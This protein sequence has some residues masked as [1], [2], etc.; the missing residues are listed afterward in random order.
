MQLP[1]TAIVAGAVG[2]VFASGKSPAFS[3]VILILDIASGAAPVLV[4]VIGCAAVESPTFS[5]LKLR[6]VGAKTIAGVAGTSVPESETVTVCVE[7]FAVSVT[8]R[9]SCADKK[10][11]PAA[12]FGSFGAN[13]TAIVHVA[14]GL[15]ADAVEAQVLEV[16]NSK[17][18]G[19]VP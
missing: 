6:E 10:S 7:L 13:C 18:A 2:H 15:R 5:L 3:P 14:P 12:G 11:P 1:L 4:T 16:L 19:F 9:A 17:S 8:E